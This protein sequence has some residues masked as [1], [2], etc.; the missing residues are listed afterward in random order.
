MIN[1]LQHN[2]L[3]TAEKI[4]AVFQASYAIEA[5]LLKATDFPPLKRTLENYINSS[6]AFF[7]YF[8]NQDL[9]AVV[10]INHT[11]QFTHIQ[12]LVVHPDYFRQGIAREFMEFVLESYDSNLFVVETGVDN[13]PATKLYLNIGF[14]EVKQWDTDFGI[15][16]VKFEKRI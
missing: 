12:S 5:K 4:R 15:R 3:Q 13:V 10:E 9:A 14:L 11:S 2:N 6:N 8:K 16:K 7:G 1:K